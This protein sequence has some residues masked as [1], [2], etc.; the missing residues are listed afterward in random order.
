[1][2][3]PSQTILPGIATMRILSTALYGLLA[4]GC[5]FASA[6]IEHYVG[7]AFDSNGLELYTESHW[8]IG[9]AGDSKRLILFSCPDGQAFARKSIDDAGH[10]QA[11][12]FQ[13]DDA[14][15][16]YREG[17]RL[18]E[19]G[20][21]EVFV[22]RRS[23][24]SEQRAL[25]ETI[26]QLVID[27]GFDWFV[28]EHWDELAAGTSL[29]VEF[30][31]PSRLRSYSFVLRPLGEVLIGGTPAL[32]FELALDAWFGFAVPSAHLAYAK[33]GKSILEYAGISNIRGGNGRNLKVRI[34][35]APAD[36]SVDPD[37]EPLAAARGASLDGRCDL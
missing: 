33:Q 36:R 4:S 18:A 21:R 13:L 10:A 7:T 19:S 34:E 15:T 28:L 2:L 26:P 37:P 32:R 14:R 29:K 24:Q 25:L 9:E 30:L 5:A 11:P 23:G 3:N 35:F 22:R 27:A 1:M 20:A 31:L 16:G 8:V 17:V 12:L 6:P